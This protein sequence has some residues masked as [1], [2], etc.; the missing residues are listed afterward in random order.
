[1]ALS[2]KGSEGNLRRFESCL[3]RVMCNIDTWEGEGGSLL[4]TGLLDATLE[5]RSLSDSVGGNKGAHRGPGNGTED[6]RGTDKGVGKSCI[7][8]EIIL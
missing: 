1:M 3:F 7:Y 4:T 5:L 6:A 8:T 2:W